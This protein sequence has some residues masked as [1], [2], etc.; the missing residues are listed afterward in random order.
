MEAS[1]FGEIREFRAPTIAARQMTEGSEEKTGGEVSRSERR[2]GTCWVAERLSWILLLPRRG[3]LLMTVSRNKKL[4]QEN[5]P[6]SETFR[7]HRD[8][9]PFGCPP[10]PIPTF[11][12]CVTAEIQSRGE[13]GSAECRP[14][15]RFLLRSCCLRHSSLPRPAY[16][17]VP[18]GEPSPTTIK[19][20]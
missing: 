18:R 15:T 13:A 3:D 20:A 16:S 6:A 10:P 14:R 5:K 9:D 2:S 11:P 4:N 19:A 8:L 17:R 7:S 1:P 12:P